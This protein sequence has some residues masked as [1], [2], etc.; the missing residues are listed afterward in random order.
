MPKKNIAPGTNHIKVPLPQ[1]E[2]KELVLLP[3]R[4]EDYDWIENQADVYDIELH[5]VV[6]ILIEKAEEDVH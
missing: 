6:R 2:R 4:T 3:I 1:G 5:D